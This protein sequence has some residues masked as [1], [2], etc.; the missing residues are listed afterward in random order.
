MAKPDST[1][2]LLVPGLLGP[3]KNLDVLRPFPKFPLLERML[4]RADTATVAGEDY[5]STLLSLWGVETPEGRDMPTAA[6]RRLGDGGIAY[7]RIWI[8][9]SPV[10]LRPDR[11]RLLLF[12]VE[13]FD[14]SDE[15]AQG[16]ISLFN[17]HFAEMGWQLD[18]PSAHRWYLSLDKLPA[19]TTHELSVV[20]GRNMDLFLPE[21][22]EALKWHSL[23]NEVQM[24][25]TTSAVNEQRENRGK[26][27]VNGA[28]FSGVGTLP[29]VSGIQYECVY[30]DDPLLTGLVRAAGIDAQP[31]D[32][33]SAMGQGSAQVVYGDLF[34]AVMRADP[35]EWSER[36]AAFEQWL[37][38][39]DGKNIL[40][41]PCNG[42]AYEIT[43]KSKRRFWHRSKPL[44][45]FVQS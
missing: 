11:D 8:Q 30:A 35:F 3:I 22:E 21:G 19:I 7:D 42:A 37:V 17:E 44:F 31:L 6:L 2:H 1:L 34:P 10:H 14:F 13:D 43:N 40:L 26:L 28:W 41:Y 4:S 32:E 20:S 25:F 5:E 16:L 33:A 23:L 29:Q 9:V 12:D 18:A 45:D 39:L 15:E 24:L 36:L 27:P 38:N